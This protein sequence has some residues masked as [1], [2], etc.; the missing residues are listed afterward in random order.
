MQSTLI[1]AVL[2][3]MSTQ[4]QNIGSQTPQRSQPLLPDTLPVQSEFLTCWK[5]E[6]HHQH[7]THSISSSGKHFPAA[8]TRRPI[9]KSW[10]DK[11][12]VWGHL[13]FLVFQKKN[14]MFITVYLKSMADEQRER[15]HKDINMN[16]QSLENPFTSYKQK[17]LKLIHW[18]G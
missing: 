6:G 10:K 18:L 16:E 3:N 2:L 5:R 15:T 9:H 4:P 14:T 17:I 1:S 13:Q 12:V 11:L 8:E 7:V